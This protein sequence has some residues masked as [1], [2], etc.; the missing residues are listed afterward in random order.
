MLIGDLNW[1][2]SVTKHAD[3]YI[4]VQQ[5]TKNESGM[6]FFDIV[7]LMRKKQKAAMNIQLS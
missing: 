7:T 1:M 3:K 5:G 2:H 6:F 4:A